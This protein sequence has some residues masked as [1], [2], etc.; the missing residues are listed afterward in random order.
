MP[1]SQQTQGTEITAEIEHRKGDGTLIYKSFTIPNPVLPEEPI[2]PDNL[3]FKA[4]VGYIK[5]MTKWRT[6]CNELITTFNSIQEYE[7]LRAHYTGDRNKDMPIKYRTGEPYPKTLGDAK[8]E[9]SILKKL[10][11]EEGNGTG[12]SNNK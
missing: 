12:T 3:N 10:I 2:A 9:I 1:L 5:Q 11:K 8:A 7:E 4:V 6:E